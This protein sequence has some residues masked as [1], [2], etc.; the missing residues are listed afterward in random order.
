MPRF[1]AEVAYEGGKFSGWQ[2]QPGLAT[3]QQALEGALTL[4]NC[5]AKVAVVGAGRTD[6]GV[7]A[8]AQVCSFELDGVWQPR[9]LLLALNA[10]LPDGVSAIRICQVR[11]EFHARFDAVSR[12]YMYFI[13]NASSIYPQLKPH[14]CWLK[15][16]RYDWSRAA[17]ACRYLEGEHDFG[18]FC[19]AADRPEDAVRTIYRVRLSRS[20]HLLKIHVVGSGF[21]TNMVR[22]MA[23]SLEQVALGKKEPRWIA[24]LLDGTCGRADCGR[25]L[26]PQGLFLWRINYDPPLWN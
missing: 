25:T 19:R 18:A 7:H 6:A 12:E 8:R 14:V 24:E 21:L 22:I 13:W 26:P 20:G 17:A 3:V 10:N 11:P 2:V 5:G 23:G 1:A 15:G 4:L 16:S 9:K